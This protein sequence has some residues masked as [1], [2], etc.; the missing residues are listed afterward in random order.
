MERSV[1]VEGQKQFD[2]KTVH[3]CPKSGKVLR[4]TD[5]VMTCDGGGM[6]FESPPGSGMIYNPKGELIH[7]GQKD[8]REKAEKQQ[9]EKDAI[10]AAAA[11][12]QKD[13]IYARAKAEVKAE[14]AAIAAEKG[15][16]GSKKE[17]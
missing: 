9:A 4:R 15:A 6:R 16:K 1:T 8:A 2:Y 14:M 7:D 5:Y 17:E 3:I 10:L 12:A 13:E 11:K